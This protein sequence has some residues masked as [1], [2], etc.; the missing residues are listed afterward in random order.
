MKKMANYLLI[1]QNEDQYTISMTSELQDDIGTIGYVEFTETNQVAV[2]DIILNLE[3]SKT[4]M[5]VL[6][7]LAG[8]IVER[9]EAASLTPTLLNSEKA[10]ENW[11]IV[12]TDV[13]Q[14]A[15]DALED[16]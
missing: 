14:A 4:V 1:E 13:D 6:S 2:D 10:E 5:S 8:T 11:I 12:L 16:A 7:P 15:F 9:N 3:A